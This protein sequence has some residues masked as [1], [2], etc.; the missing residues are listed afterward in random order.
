LFILVFIFIL[1]SFNLVASITML[2]VE[3]KNDIETLRSMGANRTD[4]FKIFFFEG[5]LISFKGIIIGLVLGY[6]VCAV[7]LQFS[8]LQMPNSNG[9]AFPIVLTITDGV[10]IVFLVSL[11]STLASYFPVRMLINRN[12]KKD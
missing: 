9:Q 7:Q 2:F 1:A 8:L 11:L 6:A 4:L 12:L 5:L 10:L 3:K